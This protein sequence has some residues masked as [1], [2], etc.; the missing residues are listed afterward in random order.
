M[1]EL[2]EIQRQ[3]HGEI[4]S[5]QENLEALNTI[6][7]ELEQAKNLVSEHITKIDEYIRSIQTHSTNLQNLLSRYADEIKEHTIQEINRAIS[8]L[9]AV[10]NEIIRTVNSLKD[11]IKNLIKTN[12]EL[13]QEAKKLFKQIDEIN[14]PKR[15][16]EIEKSIENKY[17]SLKNEIDLIHKNNSELKKQNKVLLYFSIGISIITITTLIILLMK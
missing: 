17:K 15:F 7:L 10:S 1:P 16:D 5:L 13:V 9:E 11:E 6:R 8:S 4:S 14:L 3:I 12:N 2:E